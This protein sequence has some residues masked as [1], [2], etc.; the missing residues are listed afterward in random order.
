ML[1]ISLEEY[2]TSS[3]YLYLFDALIK[4][5][6]V[7][8]RD[9]FLESLKI[10]PSTYRRTKESEGKSGIKIVNK[11]ACYFGLSTV[12]NDFITSFEKLVNNIIF[13]KRG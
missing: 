4:A 2:K 12:K 8:N 9:A 13:E 7:L 5:K 6:I 10:N 1:K 11:L 3:Q